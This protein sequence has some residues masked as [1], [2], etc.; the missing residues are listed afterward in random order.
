MYS[1]ARTDRKL[2]LLTDEEFRIW[3]NLLCMASESDTRGTLTFDGMDGLAIEVSRGD[4]ESLR[5]TMSR[6]VTLKMCH[7]TRDS[8]TF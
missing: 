1:E 2:D 4:V 3:F 6:L 5:K 7:V 8:V